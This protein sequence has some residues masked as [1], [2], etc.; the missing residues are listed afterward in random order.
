MA[1]PTFNLPTSGS[2][3]KR[4]TKEGL[5]DS[6]NQIIQYLD[7]ARIVGDDRGTEG[8]YN[9]GPWDASTGAF[10]TVRGQGGSV[11]NG[12]TFFVPDGGAGIV[13]GQPQFEVGQR[14]IA[15]V[16]NPS[17]ATYA[18]NWERANTIA[19]LA[20][21]T[22]R[23]DAM[24]VPFDTASAF[25]AA[26]I[27]DIQ[28]AANATTGTV[29][30]ETKDGIGQYSVDL[31]QPAS[32]HNWTT[33][34][35]VKVT[36]LPGS[37]GFVNLTAL[38]V[39]VT[40]TG[41]AASNM[42]AA[43]S[44]SSKVRLPPNGRMYFASQVTLPNVNGVEIDF[45]GCE[46]IIDGGYNA[47]AHV[48]GGESV[49]SV[50]S[51]DIDLDGRIITM[52]SAADASNFSGGDL[53]QI[54]TSTPWYEDDR[55]NTFKGELNKVDYVS[56]ADLFLSD[57]NADSYDVSA[58]TVTIARLT[59]LKGLRMYGGKITNNRSSGVSGGM[60][61]RNVIDPVIELEMVDHGDAIVLDSCFGG[62]IKPKVV[63]A[64]NTT[65]GYGVQTDGCRN[66]VV[67]DGFFESCRR[68]VD[69]SG[70]PYPSVGC[71]CLNNDIYLSGNMSDGGAIFDSSGASAFGSHAQAVNSVF[72]GNRAYHAPLMANSRGRGDQITNNKQYG[73][74]DHMVA[75]I[76]GKDLLLKGNEYFSLGVPANRLM[77]SL[78]LKYLRSDIGTLKVIDNVADRV[79]Q[80]V[81]A[82]SNRETDGDTFTGLTITGND[83]L[84]DPDTTSVLNGRD[85][86]HLIERF[87]GNTNAFVLE[88][89][90]LLG[91]NVGTRFG[92]YSYSTASSQVTLSV[93]QTFADPKACMMEAFPLD[94]SAI[95]WSGSGTISLQDVDLYA[96]I[97]PGR[98]HLYGYVRVDMDGAGSVR[99]DGLPHF[100]SGEPV[101]VATP[102]SVSEVWLN[103]TG[104][105][106]QS[107]LFFSS[108]VS[109]SSAALADGNHK[110]HVDV[111]YRNNLQAKL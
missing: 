33:P 73:R 43:F 7:N 30:V 70:T 62:S 44:A 2:D 108:V 88:K 109:S 84:I 51:A 32:G 26:S 3:P 5:E 67:R 63:R 47:F 20:P 28:T 86:G 81:V 75:S 58:E 42:L 13:D 55:G 89:C 34:G 48:A 104:S 4:A 99:L 57:T 36:V 16:D 77:I 39:D 40:G 21:L 103:A 111:T 18:G 82:L 23:V 17:S 87:Q 102:S 91:N 11:Q 8:F 94:V 66:V 54:R 52:D 72:D 76:F 74:A 100:I 110:M 12:D 15:L 56:G 41:N 49:Y 14:I 96:D 9:A 50:T 22:S 71:K 64:N 68:A 35:G 79:E 37:D 60:V 85:S 92:T 97:L 83:V 80:S 106:D 61:L 95:V 25:S 10:P 59:A 107:Q 45:N 53:I 98:T 24:S 65:T 78:V 1:T 6:I 38:S 101:K 69:F 19:I 31:A 27:L 46:V 105:G 93:D 90:N 29:Y